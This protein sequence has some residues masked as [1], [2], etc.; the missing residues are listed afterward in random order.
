MPRSKSDKFEAKN[1]IIFEEVS[2][3]NMVKTPV[4]NQSSAKLA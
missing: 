2:E 3:H 1:E 4:K